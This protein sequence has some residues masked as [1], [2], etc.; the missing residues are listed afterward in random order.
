MFTQSGLEETMFTQSGEVRGDNVHTKFRDWKRQCSSKVERLVQTLSETMLKSLASEL[1]ID[2]EFSR[3]VC[4]SLI[5]CVAYLQDIG[6]I[7]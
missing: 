6:S 5:N 3:E 1:A 7:C 4:R 2:F